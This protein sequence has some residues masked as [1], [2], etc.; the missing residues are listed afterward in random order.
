MYDSQTILINYI[1][2]LVVMIVW[3]IYGGVFRKRRPKQKA[4]VTVMDSD[5]IAFDDL[6][7]GVAVIFAWTESGV[8]PEYHNAMKAEVRKQMPVLGRALD[9]LVEENS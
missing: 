9:R 3:A 8:N 4:K 7:P 2:M 5:I 6:P 1:G